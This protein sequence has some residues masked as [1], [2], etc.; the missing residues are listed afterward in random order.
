MWW[1]W[2]Q[3]R[4]KSDDDAVLSSNYLPSCL[5]PFII[6]FYHFFLSVIIAFIHIFPP[7]AS[8]LGPTRVGKFLCPPSY[9]PTPVRAHRLPLPPLAARDPHSGGQPALYTL[10]LVPISFPYVR[11]IGRPNLTTLRSVSLWALDT[12]GASTG[13]RSSNVKFYLW[14]WIKE[15]TTLQ[16]LCS[17]L[18]IYRWWMFSLYFLLYSSNKS[19]TTVRNSPFCIFITIPDY[20]VPWSWWSNTSKRQH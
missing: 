19:E 13:L 12:I 10:L 11:A 4:G 17:S 18:I 6:A 15:S 16:P 1:W 2:W 20:V 3:Y 8:C 9:F 14:L 7:L 5:F